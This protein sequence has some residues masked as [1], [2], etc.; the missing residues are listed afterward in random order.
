MRNFAGDEL[1]ALVRLGVRGYEAGLE[2]MRAPDAGSDVLRQE[3]HKIK[4][5]AGTLVLAALSALAARIENDAE[6]GNPQALVEQLGNV[7]AASRA[8]LVRR[9]LLSD[10]AA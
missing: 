4:G 1:P 8:E 6:G 10:T 9:G 7:L 5:S 2:R 3:A